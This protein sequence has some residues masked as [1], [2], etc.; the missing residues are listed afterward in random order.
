MQQEE[1]QALLHEGSGSAA[2]NAYVEIEF[3]NADNRFSLE[4]AD[5]VV[6]RRTIGLHKDEFFLQR[7]RTT[8]SEI[9]SLLEG[10]G[11][12]KSN[13]YFIVQ[14]G[15]V[16][17]LCT[18]SDADRLK[19][20]Q[21]VAGT[22]V[23]DEKKAESTR[24]MQENASSRDKI[25]SLLQQMDER[26][27]ELESERDEL[28]QYSALD[29]QRRAMEYSLY[30]AE[31]TKARDLAHALEEEQHDQLPHIRQIHDAARETHQRIRLAVATGQQMRQK[32]QRNRRALQV[33][34]EDAQQAMKEFTQLQVQV[35]ELQES[36]ASGQEE[37]QRKQALLRQVEQ[38][39]AATTQELEE[40]VQPEWQAANDKLQS[41][42]DERDAAAREM[43]ALYA[44]EGRQFKTKEERDASLRENLRELEAA[45]AE[46]QEA[47]QAQRESLAGLQRTLEQEK[48]QATELQK[49]LAEKQAHL[50]TFGK[51]MDEQKRQRLELHDQRKEE[52]RKTEELR[53]QVREMREQH[54][55]AA[56]EL[57]K[58]MPRATSQGL[59]ALKTIVEQEGLEHGKQY[60][61]MLLDNFTLKNDKYRTAVNVAGQNALFHVI[62]D[63]DST[64]SRLLTRLEKEKLGRVTFLPLNQLRPEQVTYP[65]SPDVKSMLELCI[66]YE[67]AVKVAMQHVFGKKLIARSAELAAEWSTKCQ[68]DALTLEG[69]LCSRKGAISGGYM[70]SSTCR[71]TAYASQTKAKDALDQAQAAYQAAS[72][73]AK[74]L[75]QAT[76]TIMQELQTL[77]AKHSQLSRVVSQEERQLER[78]QARVAQHEKQIPNLAATA[79][80]E[81]AATALQGDM[82]RVRAELE[83]PF[84]KSLSDQERERLQELKQ[85]QMD[86][87]LQIEEQSTLVD[88]AAVKRQKL[89]SLLQDNLQVRRK[90]LSSAEDN[91]RLSSTAQQEQR[92]DELDDC[93]RRLEVQARVKEN[94]EERLAAARE[95][96]E[97]Y[98]A[99]LLAAKNEL[100]QLKS[101]DAKNAKA[102]D[103]AQQ[104]AERLA[105]KVRAVFDCFL[106]YFD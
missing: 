81:R 53:E 41:F 69:D 26:L 94:A 77:E 17:D 28:T 22:V 78:L 73:K 24:K 18:M 82:A 43:E 19:L 1:R 23:Y 79:A 46:K 12:S 60:F 66:A 10:A 71:M 99:E 75:D 3:D 89:Q 47:L 105:N 68:M 37:Y 15:K 56:F 5:T 34:N 88:Q 50:S 90:E 7:K 91:R 6:I 70:D 13:P 40:T 61:G 64:A 36:F 96:D 14:Q 32:A 51:S 59:E 63:T 25:L 30:Q 95:A 80:L 35:R 27:E 57:R 4:H 58:T 16:Q 104:K 49:K 44:K 8:K 84:T 97:T 33:A 38:E 100:E 74:E 29:R 45:A 55:R 92:K 106:G 62:V 103:D 87:G 76:T 39:I 72:A 102:L 101:Q 83:S 85:A 67:P 52:W 98:R 93:E 20:L 9:Q 21:Q 11:F 86:L 65:D 31:F 42:Q 48:S 54:G 2:V